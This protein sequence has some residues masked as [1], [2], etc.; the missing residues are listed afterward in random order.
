MLLNSLKYGVYNLLPLNITM[1][2]DHI[3]FFK[4]AFSYNHYIYNVPCNKRTIKI[5]L[6]Y[7]KT[8]QL[9]QL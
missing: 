8:F 5:Y 1:K 3:N 7:S 6:S 4:P 9:Y 2:K